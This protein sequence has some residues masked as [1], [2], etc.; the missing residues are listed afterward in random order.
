MRSDA[1]IACWIFAFT[2][3]SFLIGRVHHE[4]R[5]DERGE[6]PFGVSDPSR[7]LRAAVPDQPDDRETAEKFHQRRQD[8]ERARHSQVRSVQPVRRRRNRSSSCPSAPNALTMRWP[9]NASAVTCERCSSSSWLLRVVLRMRLPE[10]HQRIDDQRRAGDRDQREPRIHEEQ[11]RR[12]ADDRQPFAQQIAD[13]LRNRLLDL[14]HVV[15]DP[16]HQLPG[17]PAAEEGRRLIEDVPEQ[18]VAEIAH[19]PLA[20]VGHQV[21]R[22][23]GAHSLDDVDE[24]A[25]RRTTRR[26]PCRAGGRDR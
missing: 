15:R 14:V 19:D 11:I 18:L 23:I 12:E 7:D 2:R 10:S 3:L 17:R 8:G 21:G 20:D 25:A 16:R 24:P 9:V 6:V 5:G 13:R 1:A 4:R 26:G 22:R